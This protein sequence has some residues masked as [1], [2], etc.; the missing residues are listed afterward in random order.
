MPKPSAKSVAGES[1]NMLSE[2]L[3][4]TGG[5]DQAWPVAAA[6]REMSAAQFEEFL[7]LA[8]S[9]HVIVRGLEVFRG[10]MLA[11]QD[12]E[13]AEWAAAALAAER[14]RIAVAIRSLGEICDAF[15]AESLDVTV[16]KS[17]D[18]WPDLGNDLD[19]YS[20]ASPRAICDLMTRRFGARVAERSWGDRLAGKWNFEIPGLPESVE[21]HV[22]RLGQTGEQAVLASRIHAR[23]RFVDIK[24]HTFRV[25]SAADRL[26]ISTLQRMYR[27]FYFRL[28]DVVDSAAL[29][30]SGDLDFQELRAF[31]LEA[32]IWEGVATYLAIVSD[33]V[34][35]YRGTGLGLPQFVRDAA[36][37]GGDLIT[38]KDSFLRV[39][40]LPHSAGLYRTQLAGLLRRRELHSSARLGLLPWLATAAAIGQKLTGSDKG[41]W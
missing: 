17:L 16:M 23:S 39:P 30:S 38:F 31:A 24:G 32:G 35:R 5:K 41:I 29:V 22:R 2:L 13:R 7:A 15:Q 26:M 4:S 19:L 33:Y 6:A 37:F 21:V 28:C 14:S 9:N 3:L 27:H 12:G 8:S 40:I 25:P 20:N 11:G 18:H 1:M 34:C 10:I 36:R